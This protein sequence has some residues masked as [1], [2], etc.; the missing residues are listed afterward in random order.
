MVMVMVTVVMF[1]CS[2][3]CAHGTSVRTAVVAVAVVAATTAG[4]DSRL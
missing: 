4:V 2:S 1:N 3:L